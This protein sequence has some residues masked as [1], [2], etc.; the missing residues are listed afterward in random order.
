MKL[1]FQ[2]SKKFR[3]L[4]RFLA[5]SPKVFIGDPHC[6]IPAFAGMT[7]LSGSFFFCLTF[8][9]CS[10]P[11]SVIQGIPKDHPAQ[12]FYQFANQ[13]MLSDKVCRDNSGDPE[14]PIGKI[15][16]NEGYTKLEELAPGVFR[17][18]EDATSKQYLGISFMQYSG[19]LQMPKVCAWEEK[20]NE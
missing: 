7:L 1:E 19:F 11:P 13:G 2:K 20:T 9:G 10:A 15:E 3:T 4:V 14:I 6:W 5:S 16:K 8:A 17:F 18:R 12:K